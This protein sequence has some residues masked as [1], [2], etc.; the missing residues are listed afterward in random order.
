MTTTSSSRW[1]YLRGLTPAVIL[2][3]IVLGI[4][5]YAIENRLRDELEFEE[6]I[7][8]EWIFETRVGQATLAELVEQYLAEKGPDQESRRD[9]VLTHMTVLGD[10][11]RTNQGLLPLFPF[12]YR[13]ELRFK[14]K[15]Q[16]DII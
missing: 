15:I 4:I 13:M 9:A 11:T 5:I 3:A 12:V 16:N 7:L 8:K 10:L 6:N 2:F 1:R 14:P